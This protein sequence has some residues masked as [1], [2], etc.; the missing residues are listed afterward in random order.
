MEK[1]LLVEGQKLKL[2]SQHHRPNQAKKQGYN[3]RFLGGLGGAGVPTAGSPGNPGKSGP[4][5]IL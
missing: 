4:G 3:T 2:G 1:L 5:R